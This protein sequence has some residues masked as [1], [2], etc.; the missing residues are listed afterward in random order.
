MSSNLTRKEQGLFLRDHGFKP[1]AGDTGKGSHEMWENA[2]FNK[3]AAE[4]HVEIPPNL[5]MS[6]TIAQ[7]GA[8]LILPYDAGAGTWARIQKLAVW[9]DEKTAEMKQLKAAATLDQKKGST[10]AAESAEAGRREAPP[11][12]AARIAATLP[13]I[14]SDGATQSAPASA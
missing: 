6:K 1:T 3:L 5:A 11:S 12:N 14:M 10:H 9:C 4:F 2:E 8:A 13:S 7:K